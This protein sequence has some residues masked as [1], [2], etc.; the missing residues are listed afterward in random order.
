MKQLS[1][2][3]I[4]LFLCTVFLQGEEY[5]SG[6]VML[7]RDNLWLYSQDNVNSSQI[8]MIKE[9]SLVEIIDTGKTEIIN[10]IDE[11]FDWVKIRVME[12]TRDIE[13][14]AIV[15][16]TEGWCHGNY[17]LPLALEEIFFVNFPNSGNQA[18]KLYLIRKFDQNG[19][20]IYYKNS[21]GDEEWREYDENGNLVYSKDSKGFKKWYEYDERG[22]LVYGKI[23]TGKEERFNYDENGNL[24][25]AKSLDGDEEW[26]EYDEMG[27]LVH[28]KYSDGNEEWHEYDENK[29]CIHTKYSSGLEEWHD[30]DRTG[31]RTRTKYS[32][33]RE[34]RYD[35]TGNEIYYKYSD[36]KKKLV[37]IR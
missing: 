21:I 27:N 22:N 35:K 12:S 28:S 10:D 25:Y 20:E 26:H 29:N 18:V 33:G 6:S 19:N 23:S 17:L 13:G 1:I 15:S 5:I 4:S 3:L 8:T 32:D 16:G 14:K 24:I 11:P 34:I 2:F 7:L 37:Q 36:G 9:N 30:Y 31:N